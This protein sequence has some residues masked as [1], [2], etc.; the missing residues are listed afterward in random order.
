MEHDGASAAVGGQRPEAIRRGW[1]ARRMAIAAHGPL[2][3]D[4]PTTRRRGT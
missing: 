4:R 2:A 3:A 1:K